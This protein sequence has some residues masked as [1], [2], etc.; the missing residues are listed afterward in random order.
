MKRLSI[1]R[2]VALLVLLLHGSAFGAA[3]V[4]DALIAA[5]ATASVAHVEESSDATCVAHD[6]STCQLC[7]VAGTTLCSSPQGLA[8]TP[9]AVNARPTGYVRTPGALI[10]PSALHS[11]APPI[12]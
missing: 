10:A 1:T 2:V 3:A 5:R 9:R 8:M 11:R 12:A 6:E 7:R 4:L